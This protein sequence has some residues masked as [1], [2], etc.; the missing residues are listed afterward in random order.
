MTMSKKDAFRLDSRQLQRI[1]GL[2]AA[3][4]R[5]S[6]SPGASRPMV[7]VQ[8]PVRDMPGYRQRFRDPLAM[9]AVELATLRNHLEIGDDCVPTVRVQFGTGLIASAFGCETYVPDDELPCSRQ[10]VIGERDAIAGLGMPAPDAGLMGRLAEFTRVFREHLPEGV[11]IQHPDIQSPFNNAYAIR[12]NDLFLDMVDDPASVEA[13][14]D[15]VTDYLIATV[16]RLKAMIG[17]DRGWFFDMGVLWKG[18]ARISNCSTTMIDPRMYDRFVLPRDRRLLRA[19]GGGRI[20]YCG[21]SPAVIGSF[22]GIPGMSGLDYDPKLHDLWSMCE[23]VPA[24]VVLLQTVEPDSAAWR[25]LVAGD[26]PKKRNIVIE[27]SAN[28]VQTGKELLESLKASMS[29]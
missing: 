14:L 6:T 2:Y 29:A 26:W 9:L 28:D 13:L 20:H 11:H 21:T 15:L 4:R 1:E 24:N 18:T 25:R 16:P 3:Y 8:V 5:M 22:L 19:I 17:N 12:G 10:P 23:M 27:T 7:I